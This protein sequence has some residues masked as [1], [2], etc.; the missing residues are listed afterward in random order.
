MSTSRRYHSEFATQIM[1]E[2]T[3]AV[4]SVVIPYS[5]EYTP[6]HMLE[7]AKESATEQSVKT[8]LIVVRDTEQRGPAWARNEGI[9][10][11]ST[12]FV[13]FLDADDLWL[14]G[15][16]D[17]QLRE[18]ERTGAGL[19][20]EYA[21]E[22]FDQLI[23]DL[24]L[25]S[26]GSMT[27]SVLID[28]ER[29]TTRF[30]QSLQGRE[31]HLF[32]LEAASEGGVCFQENL[33]EIRKHDGGLSASVDTQTAYEIRREY[34]SRVEQ[35]V[36]EARDLVVEYQIRIL[37]LR[38]SVHLLRS[39]RTAGFFRHLRRAIAVDGALQFGTQCLKEAI[40]FVQDTLFTSRAT[41]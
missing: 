38:T 36:P 13:A 21:G 4:V 41:R 34:I 18:M 6:E 16:L 20:V 32:I 19:C 8:E 15:K 3:E 28:T 39:F 24:L 40:R 12:R 17:K 25:G 37:E 1:N 30:D 14:D 35:R 11:A 10:R 27:S 9:K 7:A 31:D 33:T 5:A 2:Y 29:I 23:A 22:S 26:A